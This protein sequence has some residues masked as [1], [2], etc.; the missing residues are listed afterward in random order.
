[1]LAALIV[2]L[3]LQSPQG[4]TVRSLEKGAQSA[5]DMPKQ[6]TVRTPADWAALWQPQASNHPLPDV[7]FGRE[8]VVGVFLGTRNSAGYSVEIVGAEIQQGALIVRYR[9]STP[10][11]GAITAQ[12]ITSPY[13]LVAVPQH[14]GVVRFEKLER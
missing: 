13:H 7:D 2:A 14:D 6:L 11:P 4:V 3:L 12:V 5:V 1:M 8:M 9:E 10:P